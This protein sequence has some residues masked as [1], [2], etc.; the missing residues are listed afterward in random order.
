MSAFANCGRA[1]AHVRG[2]YVPRSEVMGLATPARFRHT[3]GMVTFTDSSRRRFGPIGRCIYCGATGDLTR[4]HIIPRSIGGTWVL[5]KASCSDCAAVTRDFEGS[6]VK[7]LGACEASWAFR[8]R[9]ISEAAASGPSRSSL[10]TALISAQRTCRL[11]WLHPCQFSFQT[12]KQRRERSCC[13]SPHLRS[14]T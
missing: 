4:E 11:T 8:A 1:V 13:G 6:R 9:P 12:I 2:S 5:S 14:A 7:C 3:G 10:A